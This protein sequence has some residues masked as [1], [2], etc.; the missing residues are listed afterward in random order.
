VWVLWRIWRKRDGVNLEESLRFRR[1][2]PQLCLCKR[3]DEIWEASCFCL[4]WFLQVREVGV[5]V[6]VENGLRRW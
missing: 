4:I 1:R 3:M 5:V 6:E 2:R